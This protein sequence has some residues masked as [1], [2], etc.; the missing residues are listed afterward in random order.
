MSRRYATNGV[1]GAIAWIA[2]VN[3]PAGIGSV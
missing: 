3:S 1:S 2:R